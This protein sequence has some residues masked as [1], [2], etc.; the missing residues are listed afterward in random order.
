MRSGEWGFSPAAHS[1]W[2][3]QVREHKCISVSVCARVASYVLFV[4][5]CIC[6]CVRVACVHK[7]VCQGCVAGGVVGC[8]GGSLGFPVGVLFS[9]C[10]PLCLYVGTHVY[11]FAFV[12]R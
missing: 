9:M 4:H 2:C 6:V 10:L 12:P 1:G 3:L 11:L 5:S 8:V 7:C